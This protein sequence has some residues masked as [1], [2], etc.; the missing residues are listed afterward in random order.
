MSRIEILYEG[1]LS[2]RAVFLDSG[3]EVKT[4]YPKLSPTELFASSLGSCVLTIMALAAQKM[5]IE[6]SGSKVFVDKEMSRDLPRRVSSLQVHFISPLSFPKE[7]SEEL[8]KAGIG[9]PVH[10]SLHPDMKIGFHFKWGAP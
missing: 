5:G 1:N 7:I 2:T 10:H 3:L 6:L 8:E 9:C 4:E